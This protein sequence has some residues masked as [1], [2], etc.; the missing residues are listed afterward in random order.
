MR[1]KDSYSQ[2]QIKRAYG[3]LK[4]SGYILVARKENP[5]GYAY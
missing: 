3:F 1:D 5:K 4:V 2:S